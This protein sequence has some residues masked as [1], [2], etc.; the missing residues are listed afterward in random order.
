MPKD[1]D[2]IEVKVLTN[3]IYPG[4][5]KQI[6]KQGVKAVLSGGPVS[7]SAKKIFKDKKIWFRE[8]VE[9]GDLDYEAKEHEVGD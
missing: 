9:P 4:K 1:S 5:A 2:Y 8:N 7:D 3:G 6:I